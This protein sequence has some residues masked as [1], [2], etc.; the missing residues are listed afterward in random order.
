MPNNHVQSITRTNN[1]KRAQIYSCLVLIN[2]HSAR[3]QGF[4]RQ[5]RH[6]VWKVRNDNYQSPRPGAYSYVQIR[7]VTSPVT[8]DGRETFS[9]GSAASEWRFSLPCLKL[10]KKKGYVAR[11]IIGSLAFAIDIEQPWRPKT[12][13]HHLAPRRPR[14][15]S[16]G[17][18]LEV[19][20]A[21]D[22]IERD[23]ERAYGIAS[24]GPESDT[25]YYYD[26]QP[27]VIV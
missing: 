10:K 24:I 2:T 11:R 21:C 26:F 23:S 13:V 27:K 17:W 8:R 12:A 25:V 15:W 20:S 4:C 19:T 3:K 1:L 7:G 5:S 9:R 18:S 14:G 22:N 16:L 6:L